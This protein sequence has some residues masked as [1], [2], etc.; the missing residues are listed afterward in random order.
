ML[1]STFDDW[2]GEDSRSSQFYRRWKPGEI[3]VKR[4]QNQS[5]AHF[6][7]A[8]AFSK[9]ITLWA[10][11][12][13]CSVGICWDDSGLKSWIGAGITTGTGAGTGTGIGTPGTPIIM[14]F[15]F[16]NCWTDAAYGSIAIPG[17][18]GCIKFCCPMKLGWPMKFGCTC[19]TCWP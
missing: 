4:F 19:I 6:T 17:G 8:F 12:F 2:P 10:D 14:G 11:F 16:G 18:S 7:L 15:I 13:G 1:V 9:L 5:V 3:L